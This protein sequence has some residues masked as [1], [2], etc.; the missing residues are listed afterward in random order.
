ML[1]PTSASKRLG[2]SLGPGDLGGIPGAGA[3]F[4]GLQNGLRTVE[5]EVGG[6]QGAAERSTLRVTQFRG[7]TTELTVGEKDHRPRMGP[8]PEMEAILSQCEEY[9]KHRWGT[10]ESSPEVQAGGGSDT[11][12]EVCKGKEFG[13]AATQSLRMTR[14]MQSDNLVKPNPNPLPTPL[15]GGPVAAGG[16]AGGPAKDDP[17]DEPLE[18]GPKTS[19]RT[20]R[21]NRR[22]NSWSAGQRRS[23]DQ[24]EGEPQYKLEKDGAASCPEARPESASD[25]DESLIDSC[26]SY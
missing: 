21:R 3:G 2:L 1:G 12:P 16:P 14:L 6:E 22:S 20:R 15:N 13:T 18:T 11:K 19:P 17:D 26:R 23:E 25:S 8:S 9:W 7:N 24:P 10:S 4:G 5:R